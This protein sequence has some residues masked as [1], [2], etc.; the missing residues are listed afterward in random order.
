M[1][2]SILAVYKQFL[3]ILGYI[4][5]LKIISLAPFTPRGALT[6][7]TFGRPIS[8]SPL[9]NLI[10]APLQVINHGVQRVGLGRQ[11]PTRWTP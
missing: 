3:E 6:R 8:T 7:T 2:L 5:N 9:L 11:N 10:Y 4:G 1:L